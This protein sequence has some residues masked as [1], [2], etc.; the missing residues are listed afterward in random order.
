VTGAAKTGEDLAF[1]LA[2]SRQLHIAIARKDD[3]LCQEFNA[4]AIKEQ[5]GKDICASS[6]PTPRY[7]PR[8]PPSGLVKPTAIVAKLRL[9]SGAE[10]KT[11]WPF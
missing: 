11:P 10:V 6:A 7:R 9:R 3:S 8:E 1:I 2:V 5:Q 4:V